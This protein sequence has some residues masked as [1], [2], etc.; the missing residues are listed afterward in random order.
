MRYFVL[1]KEVKWRWRNEVLQSQSKSHSV[2]Y[3]RRK[4]LTSSVFFKLYRLFRF[5]WQYIFSA[6]F[7]YLDYDYNPFLKDKIS[8]S[9]SCYPGEATP[10]K[11]HLAQLRLLFFLQ[12]VRGADCLTVFIKQL[13]K[14]LLCSLSWF[15]STVVGCG[16]VPGNYGV[17]DEK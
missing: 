8:E 9:F 1:C 12:E 13:C 5:L 10:D 14:R 4:N 6:S 3:N 15:E 2:G 17:V 7:S 11:R 16:W